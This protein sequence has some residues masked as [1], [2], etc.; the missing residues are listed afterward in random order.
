MSKDCM[1]VLSDG[2]QSRAADQAQKQQAS[3]VNDVL[4]DQAVPFDYGAS[5]FPASHDTASARTGQPKHVVLRWQ[6]RNS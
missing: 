5:I 2:P 6:V 3:N 4:G 1:A